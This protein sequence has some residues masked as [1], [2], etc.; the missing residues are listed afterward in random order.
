MLKDAMLFLSSHGGVNNTLNHVMEE[1]P[2]HPIY[3]P[4]VCSYTY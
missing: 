1:L 2:S 3:L 4:T